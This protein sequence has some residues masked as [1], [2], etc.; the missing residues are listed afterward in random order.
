MNS[1]K[2]RLD[3]LDRLE[4]CGSGEWIVVPQYYGMG[5]DEAV[6][7]RFGPQGAPM[8]ARLII[9]VNSPPPRGFLFEWDDW[10]DEDRA[11]AQGL[12]EHDL[13]NLRRAV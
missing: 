11:A 10:T 7:L 1:L 6:R 5:E 3:R 2:R 13:E 12:S 8:G 9:V 4:N